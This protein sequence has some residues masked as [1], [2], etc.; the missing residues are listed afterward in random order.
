MTSSSPITYRKTNLFG[1]AITVELPS[2]M[3]NAE[4]VRPISDTQEVFISTNDSSQAS[5][6]VDLQEYVDAAAEYQYVILH[7]EILGGPAHFAQNENAA[8]GGPGLV[9]NGR[10]TDPNHLAEPPTPPVDVWDAAKPY[11]AL[12]SG[13]YTMT[14]QLDDTVIPL[15]PKLP[16]G[17][18]EDACED[19]IAFK[20]HI[21]DIADAGETLVFDRSSTAIS[22]LSFPGIEAAEGHEQ[23]HGVVAYG[24]RVRVQT[25]AP[26]DSS[27]PQGYDLYLYLVRLEGVMCDILI[28]IIV[29]QGDK[30][31]QSHVMEMLER[32]RSSLKI[33]DWGLFSDS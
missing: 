13:T 31:E 11:I 4:T 16:H 15:L 24:S 14:K 7:D 8:G 3:I 17:V 30:I 19:I 27:R 33:V 6:I 25:N 9:E 29:Q 21:L 22:M 1:G 12:Q 32:I 5:I 20:A 23:E 28:Y 18:S 10:G 26:V 2:F